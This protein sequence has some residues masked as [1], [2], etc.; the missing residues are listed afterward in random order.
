MLKNIIIETWRARITGNFDDLDGVSNVDARKKQ[1]YGNV[2]S[3]AYRQFYDKYKPYLFLPFNLITIWTLSDIILQR[4]EYRERYPIIWGI[5]TTI[6]DNVGYSVF[7]LS[8]FV[9]LICW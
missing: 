8:N 1:R 7:G 3:I 5:L 2:G 6:Q 9:N 4:I